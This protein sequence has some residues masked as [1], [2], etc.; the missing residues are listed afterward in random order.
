MHRVHEQGLRKEFFTQK[1]SPTETQ[2]NEEFFIQN[3]YNRWISESN[4]FISMAQ[5]E[6]N[7]KIR[8]VL[9]NICSNKQTRPLKI[10][11][12]LIF[13][14]QNGSDPHILIYT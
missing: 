10:D 5:L 13:M 11:C 7:M 6:W 2:R 14:K 12:A 3:D 8:G 9:L 4:G 1:Q